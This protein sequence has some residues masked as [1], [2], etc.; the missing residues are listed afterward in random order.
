MNKKILALAIP[1]IISNV[2]IPL[3]S[4]VDTILMGHLS[5]LHLA[6][7]GLVGMIFL[8]LYGTMNFLRKGT[9]G[10]TAQ[11]FGRE[12]KGLL[13]KTLYRALSLAF[14]LSL[15]PLFFQDF[16]LESSFYLMNVEESYSTYAQ[17]YFSIRI[18]TAPAVFLIYVLMG[19]FFGMQNAIYPLMITLLINFLNILCSYYFVNVLNMG[20]EGAAYGTVVAQYAGLILAF[21]LLWRY[22]E[23]LTF[24]SLLEIFKFN[25]F[26][27]FLRINRDIFVRTLLLTFSFVFFYAQAAKNGEETLTV[28]ILL[29]QFI[30]WFAYITDG[31][32][33]AAESLVGRYY[34]AQDWKSFIKVIKYI[35][36][37]GTGLSFV[38]ML[39]YAFLGEAILH[40]YTNDQALIDRTLQFLPYVIFMPIV[41][42]MAYIWDGIF[43]GM[44]ATKALR[45]ITIFSTTLFIGVFYIFKGL[46]FEYVLWVSFMSFFLFRGLFQS[47]VFF[48]EGRD[49]K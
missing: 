1:N 16:I 45:N 48:K 23:N 42:F 4:T 14:I 43:V 10:V 44:T 25:E 5:T 41:S 15:L 13:S 32:A 40:I 36:I 46:N 34:G 26:F 6:A 8:F 27:V 37:W 7:L 49:L 24:F 17:S 21:L 9:T 31:F 30:I 12:D 39:V 19:W 33:N 35:F 2:S 22:R 38:Y 11:A 20:I 47:W 3:V 18:Y 28:M 29:L